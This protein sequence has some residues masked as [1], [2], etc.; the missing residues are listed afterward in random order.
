LL[1]CSQAVGWQMP[2]VISAPYEFSVVHNTLAAV[3]EK[4]SCT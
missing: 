3:I 2:L 4:K 1:A